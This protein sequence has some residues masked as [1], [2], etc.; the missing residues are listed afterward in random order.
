MCSCKMLLKELMQTPMRPEQKEII[1][2]VWNITRGIYPPTPRHLTDEEV[3]LVFQGNPIHTECGTIASPFRGL[4]ENMECVLL[5]PYLTRMSH[6]AVFN[7][8]QGA[9]KELHRKINII[10]AIAQRFSATCN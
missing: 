7:L 6:D 9:V 2:I 8:K 4:N 5:K 10:L 3:R 1:Q